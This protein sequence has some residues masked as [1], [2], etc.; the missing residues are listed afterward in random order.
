M[1]YLKSTLM[2]ALAEL[3]AARE[4]EA[5]NQSTP[6]Y[7]PR[8]RCSTC[9]GSDTARPLWISLESRCDS[10]AVDTLV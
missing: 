9:G 3:A 6:V 8:I 10:H 5:S 4:Y 2:S 1:N 7:V